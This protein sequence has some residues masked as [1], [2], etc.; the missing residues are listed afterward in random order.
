[1]SSGDIF[2]LRKQEGHAAEALEMARSEYKQNAD[3][4]W[5]VRAYAWVLYDH[6]KKIVDDHEDKQLSPAALS[7]KLSPVMR[8][9][10]KIAAPLR[11]DSAFSQMLR[12][13]G[14]VS[15]DWQQFLGFAHWAGI[16]DFSDDD[17]RPFV[18]DQGKTIDSLEKRFVRAICRESVARLSDPQ[19]DQKMV[20]WGLSILEQAL[21]E[22]PNDQWLNFNQSKVHLARGETDLA[23]KRLL[24]VLHRQSRLAWPWV[25][26]G[27]I[28]EVTRPVDSLTCFAHATELA[29]EEQ[30]VAK[31]R[32]HLAQR[33]SVLGRFG[34]AA[35]QA[36]LALKYRE[37][38]GYKVPQE[39]QQLVASDWY[40]KAVAENS[41]QR[42][43][44]VDT[45]TKELLQQLDQKSLTFT[46][47][48]IDHIN[49]EKAL[50]YVATGITTGFGLLHR[51]FPQIE[52][53]APGTM[54]EVGVAEPEGPPLDWRL[55]NATVLPGLCETLSGSLERQ[56]GKDFAFIRTGHE[57]VFVPPSLARDFS[58]GQSHDVT[59]LAIRRTNKQGKTGWRVVH[60]IERSNY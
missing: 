29:R 14:K 1:M 43:K 28:L 50:S 3:D 24:P 2:A 22:E 17:N 60:F 48:V 55:S 34:E 49:V 27:E 52:G 35:R 11:K 53:L 7:A 16:A 47:G 39:L 38:H 30:E 9:F 13:A 37:Q 23:I 57:E 21:L 58:A 33:L 54:V 41:L 5:L 12:L 44:N 42:L 20:A 15:R 59:C 10:A 8:E 45:S 40:Q 32:I 36:D 56:E 26:L 18:N 25:L 6:A 46:S 31:V 19:S 4:I 51:K